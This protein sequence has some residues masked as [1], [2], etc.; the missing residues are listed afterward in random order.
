MLGADGGCLLA[1]GCCSCGKVRGEHRG[2]SQFCFLSLFVIQFNTCN[3]SDGNCKPAIASGADAVI[4][5]HVAF[6]ELWC[7]KYDPFK[8]AIV[9]TGLALTLYNALRMKASKVRRHSTMP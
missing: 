5:W 9:L 3:S 2:E 6:S 4:P 1:A 8:G 7:F